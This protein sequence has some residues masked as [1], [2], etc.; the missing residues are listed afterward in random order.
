MGSRSFNVQNKL[1]FIW[2]MLSRLLISS[3]ENERVQKQNADIQKSTEN[4]LRFYLCIFKKN[5]YDK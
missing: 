1:I 3:F 5:K 4:N 2:E